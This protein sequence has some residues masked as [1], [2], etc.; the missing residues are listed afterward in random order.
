[1][2]TNSLFNCEGCTIDQFEEVSGLADVLAH[3]NAVCSLAQ[4]GIV[5][6]AQVLGGESPIIGAHIHN[7]QGASVIKFCGNGV[8][9][10]QAC[11]A[12]NRGG[13][14]FFFWFL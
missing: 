12:Y 5:C 10:A 3:G 14:F 7:R 13:L 6:D 9:S 4:T 1:M 8:S 2:S 11:A